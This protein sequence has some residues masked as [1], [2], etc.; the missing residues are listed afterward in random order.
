M[1]NQSLYRSSL[2]PT[3]CLHY[4][5]YWVNQLPRLNS[6]SSAW[7]ATFSWPSS[8]AQANCPK[9]C[10]LNIPSARG[11]CLHWF[12]CPNAKLKT[13]QP[14]LFAVPSVWLIWLIIIL[15]FSLL[16]KLMNSIMITS[17][18]RM[19]GWSQVII[20]V[21]MNCHARLLS[22]PTSNFTNNYATKLMEE[23][24]NH[25]GHHA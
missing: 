8:I 22:C 5:L 16:I 18:G 6:Y 2:K 24:V 7:P 12:K 23:L 11:N 21:I 10:I 19:N 9:S 1:T 14:Y 13:L 3:F 20:R 25:M 17:T 4:F 15:L